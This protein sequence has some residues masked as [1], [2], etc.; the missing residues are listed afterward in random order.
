MLHKKIEIMKNHKF[1]NLLNNIKNKNL[2]K[3]FITFLQS[4]HLTDEEIKINSL[5]CEEIC[6]NFYRYNDTGK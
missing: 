3:K 5:L 6:S 4:T 2:K 1:I